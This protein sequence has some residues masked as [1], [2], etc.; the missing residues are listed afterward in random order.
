[1]D[2]VRVWDTPPGSP[3]DLITY[4]GSHSQR[5]AFSPNSG[6]LAADRG[7]AFSIRDMV[8]ARTIRAPRD[9][10]EDAFARI[11]FSPDSRM[12]GSSSGTTIQIWTLPDA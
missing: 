2:A 4:V 7:S 6:L 3:A 12:L 1:M 11:A 10:D 9:T 8:T 5:L